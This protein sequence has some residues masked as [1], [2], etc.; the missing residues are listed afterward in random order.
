MI[1]HWTRNYLYIVSF[2]FFF[3][4]VTTGLN[5]LLKVIS[6]VGDQRR[7]VLFKGGGWM[8]Y[9]RK[10]FGCWFVCFTMK[11]TWVCL[12]C[13][14]FLHLIFQRCRSLNPEEKGLNR[15]LKFSGKKKN[16]LQK[17]GKAGQKGSR[18]CRTHSRRKNGYDIQSGDRSVD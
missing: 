14:L 12:Y 4:F 1:T 7:G 5:G 18:Q 17:T 6:F 16:R 13:E 8:D 9:E 3:Q 15:L 2:N 10:C 11:D